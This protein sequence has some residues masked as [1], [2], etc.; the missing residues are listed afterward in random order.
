VLS[1][2]ISNDVGAR[3]VVTTLADTGSDPAQRQLS[4]AEP[5][6]RDFNAVAGLLPIPESPHVGKPGERRLE[7]KTRALSSQAVHLLQ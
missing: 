4:G 6:I 3:Y 2:V 7:G 5:K 1:L